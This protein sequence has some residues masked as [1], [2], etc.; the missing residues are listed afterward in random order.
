MRNE[1][2]KFTDFAD[3]VEERIGGDYFEKGGFKIMTGTALRAA[4]SKIEPTKDE[5]TLS[6]V[7]ARSLAEKI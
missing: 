6:Q 2:G 5:L 7:T 4:F 3:K 1:Q